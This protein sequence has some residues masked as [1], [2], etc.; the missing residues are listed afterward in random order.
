MKTRY[1]IQRINSVPID[2]TDLVDL[3]L[4]FRDLVTG[5]EVIKEYPRRRVEKTGPDENGMYHYQFT[6]TYQEITR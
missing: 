2:G 6:A 4:T 5:E 1:R 3:T